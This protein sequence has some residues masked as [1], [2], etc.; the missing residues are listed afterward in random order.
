[1]TPVFLASCLVNYSLISGI[2]E[3]A[4][5]HWP[6]AGDIQMQ[7][8]ELTE[9]VK[10]G[11]NVVFG[12]HEAVLPVGDAAVPLTEEAIQALLWRNTFALTEAELQEGA[13]T[14]RK[15]NR[16]PTPSDKEAV[17]KISFAPGEGGFS[18]VTETS[19][20]LVEKAGRIYRM[21]HPLS[22]D[23]RC[24]R[25]LAKGVHRSG[26]MA[27]NEYLLR[28]RPSDSPVIRCYR[29]GETEGA[30]REVEWGWDGVRWHRHTISKPRACV[31]L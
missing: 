15:R 3:L 29:T 28:V 8:F 31:R 16:M 2:R 10:Q 6:I 4:R 27:W 19:F 1:M 18:E 20:D 24:V 21:Y 26:G 11:V 14:A 12:E 23:S 30:P 5:L 17:V 22:P 7:V 9:S 25:V 13:L